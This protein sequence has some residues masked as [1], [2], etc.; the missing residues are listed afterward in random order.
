MGYYLS[1]VDVCV[2]YVTGMQE[3][4]DLKKAEKKK[5]LAGKMAAKC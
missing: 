1:A 2:R 4:E 3:Q 5:E